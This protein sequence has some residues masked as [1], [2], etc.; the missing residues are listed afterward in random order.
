M[1]KNKES[2]FVVREGGGGGGSQYKKKL[3]SPCKAIGR[4]LAGA[5]GHIYMGRWNKKVHDPSGLQSHRGEKH[6]NSQWFVPK[7]GL[8]H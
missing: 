4:P 3:S 6:S 1:L 2:I 5:L 8:Q 7:T